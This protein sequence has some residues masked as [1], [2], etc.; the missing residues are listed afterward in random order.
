MAS[1]AACTPAPAQPLTIE[2]A[3]F[4]PPLGST[5][6]GAAYFT[7]R[8]AKDDAIIAVTS[9]AADSVEI[10]TSVTKDGRATMQHIETLEL[11]AGKTVRFEPGGNHLMVFSPRVEASA[12]AFPITIE[13]QSG[14]RETVSFEIVP[15]GGNHPD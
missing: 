9:S 8:S 14:G 15:G 3:E 12:S 13:L 10:H 6:I 4:R 5:G 7:I 1:L 2:H 11:P